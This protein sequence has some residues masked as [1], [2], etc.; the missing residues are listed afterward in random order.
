M[1]QLDSTNGDIWAKTL[2]LTKFNLYGRGLNS[3]LEG[4]HVVML[5]GTSSFLL[6]VSDNSSLPFEQVLV[7]LAWTSNLS[8]CIHVIPYLNEMRLFETARQAPT[9][10]RFV[11]PGS[12]RAM[13]EVLDLL[14]AEYSANRNQVV[15][16]ALTSFRILRQEL[17]Q[18]DDET[19]V[20][21]AFNALLTYAELIESRIV[22]D[23]CETLE[24]CINV[25]QQQNLPYLAL[26]QVDSA[27]TIPISPII[28]GLQ[29]GF[30][31][32]RPISSHLLL[33]HA[34]SELYQEAHLLIGTPTQFQ[35]PGLATGNPVPGKLRKDVRFT[36]SGLARSLASETLELAHQYSDLTRDQLLILDPACGSG[37]FLKEALR[38]LD[39]RGCAK[40]VSIRG[41]D[42]SPISVEMSRFILG[43]AKADVEFP[44]DISIE[45]GDALS[46]DW[47]TPDVVLMNPPFIQ[48][49]NLQESERKSAANVLGKSATGRFDLSMA[50]ITKATACL[51]KGG[52]VTSLLPAS[53]LETRAGELWRSNLAQDASLMLVGRFQGFRLF[54]SSTVEI[55]VVT[56]KAVPPE[57]H[58]STLL[59]V[60]ESNY[61]SP[62]LQAI[63]ELH[64]DK[65]QGF[66]LKLVPQS[67][68]QAAS[69]LPRN[70]ATLELR[71]RL[72]GLGLP[73]VTDLFEVKQGIRT[74]ANSVF[75]LSV[76]QLEA[77][78]LS[79]RA[80][81]RPTVGQGSIRGGTISLQEYVFYHFDNFGN[82]LQTEDDVKREVPHFY[83]S[84]LLP[85]KA[86][87]ETRARKSDAN[88][89]KLSEHR[90]WLVSTVPKIVSTYFGSSGSFGF[91]AVGNLAVV[92]GF[93]WLRSETNI[94]TQVSFEDVEDIVAWK[95]S[96]SPFA[97]L[98]ILNSEFFQKVLSLHCPR[99]QGGQFDLSA[100]YMNFVPVPDL[101]DEIRVPPDV[102]ES[103]ADLGEAIYRAQSISTGLLEKLVRFA[104]GLD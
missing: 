104:Y 42:I 68:I 14:H 91:D 21:R 69:W 15:Q 94:N 52:Y 90:S 81:F 93:G 36:P 29:N 30:G 18:I 100:R 79:E 41:I 1:I 70:L 83:N 66:Q 98:A 34:S 19:E 12:E 78:P 60:A 22:N 63:R 74:G 97:F 26:P 47:G 65:S 3:N 37:I 84:Y 56:I 96:R 85:N 11:P 40:P 62:A 43:R 23:V 32:G 86:V 51:R 53:L 44:V 20:I 76:V 31:L 27:N 71:E 73:K 80:W 59:L 57:V 55:G 35:L 46:M 9:P 33:R 17:R 48:V 89:W 61:E 24:D 39:R 58:S 77:L 99:V 87:L 67:T 102:V 10:R 45:V 7:D 82:E 92:Q 49:E 75:L 5:N 72:A 103:L 64:E 88:W 95:R 6:S 4:Q 101:E 28:R 16:V 50:F 2:G 8:Y 25:L 54:R 38:D 13:R